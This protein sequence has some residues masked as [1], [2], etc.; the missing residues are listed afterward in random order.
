MK[1]TQ[2]EAEIFDS[3]LESMFKGANIEDCL[4]AY[5]RQAKELEPLLRASLAIR[6]TSLNIQPD[7]HFKAIVRSHLQIKAEKMRQKE[8]KATWFFSYYKRL[9]VAMVSVMVVFLVGGGV[10]LASANALPD[11]SLYP[12][13]LAGEQLRLAVTFT[14]IDR[15]K[16]HVQFAERRADEMVEMA[17]QGERDMVST[18]T[19]QITAHIG[20]LNG[21]W[22]FPV[23]Q[24]ESANV[25]A[26]AEL[27]ESVEIR[28]SDEDKSTVDLEEILNQ[29]REETFY[30][31][32]AA[33]YSAPE[34]LKPILEQAIE[35]LGN[36]YSNAISIVKTG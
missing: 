9:T 21:I 31:L 2:N 13:K 35:N 8:H 6:Q 4:R 22:E 33:L 20:S 26:P 12:I 34:D 15:A 17:L 19:A 32:Q 36:D 7:Y 27:P 10:L 1:M 18:L 5:P 28:T 3:C 14:E 30:I 11:E 16:V 23:M 24:G 29:S 25:F